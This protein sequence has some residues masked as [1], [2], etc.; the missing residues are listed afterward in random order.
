[1]DERDTFADEGLRQGAAYATFE[2][3]RYP[4][5]VVAETRVARPAA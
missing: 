4:P 5:R 2:I 1:M 3:R